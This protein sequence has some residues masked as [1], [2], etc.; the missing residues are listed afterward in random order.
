MIAPLE[1]GKPLHRRSCRRWS[2]GCLADEGGTSPSANSGC[3]GE[4]SLLL[5][6]ICVVFDE[7]A[8]KTHLSK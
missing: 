6:M 1:C 4:R 3:S 5:A 8:P 7:D 2:C